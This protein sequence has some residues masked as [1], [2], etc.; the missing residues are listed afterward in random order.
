MLKKSV[1]EESDTPIFAQMKRKKNGQQHYQ[2]EI[3]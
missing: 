2:D 1:V 3:F